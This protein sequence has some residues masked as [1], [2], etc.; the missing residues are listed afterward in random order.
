MERRVVIKIQLLVVEENEMERRSS[1]VE[2]IL[3]VRRSI[4]FL[5]VSLYPLDKVL[6]PVRLSFYLVLMSFLASSH[7]PICT[8]IFPRIVLYSPYSLIKIIS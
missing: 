4:L 3:G 2:I 6:S 5:C 8:A 7:I 1:S